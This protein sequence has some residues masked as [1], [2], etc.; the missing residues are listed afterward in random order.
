MTELLANVE[1]YFEQDKSKSC[2]IPLL[3]KENMQ[4]KT[5]LIA[6]RPPLLLLLLLLLFSMST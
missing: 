3:V 1:V 4:G 5:K 2:N 6:Y